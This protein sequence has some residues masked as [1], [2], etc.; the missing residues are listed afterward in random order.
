MPLG[1]EVR[2]DRT[3]SET[4]L[5]KPL[6]LTSQWC[7]C[8]KISDTWRGM[9]KF[10][11]TRKT[12][13]RRVGFY[14][15]IFL[16]QIGKEVQSNWTP[17]GANLRK[18]LHFEKSGYPSQ[19]QNIPIADISADFSLTIFPASAIDNSAKSVRT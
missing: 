6:H 13:Q 1:K 5:C 8:V 18:P 9:L 11:T 19:W 7:L 4:S 15:T 12:S 17:F 14:P 10:N 3:P 16:I 2:S